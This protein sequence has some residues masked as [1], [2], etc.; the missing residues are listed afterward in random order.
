MTLLDARNIELK[1]VKYSFCIT[2][3][4]LTQWRYSFCESQKLGL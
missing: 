4:D 2:A 3:H 1:N